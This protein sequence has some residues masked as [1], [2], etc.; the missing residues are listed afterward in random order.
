MIST[1]IK[2]VPFHHIFY[3]KFSNLATTEP[4]FAIYLE[5]FLICRPLSQKLDDF[6]NL[7]MSTSNELAVYQT[8]N[9]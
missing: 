4:F 2:V 7:V 3:G 5:Y 8:W 9:R 6:V 1:I